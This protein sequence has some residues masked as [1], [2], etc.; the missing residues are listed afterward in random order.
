M[1][2]TAASQMIFF[3]AAMIVATAVAGVFVTTVINLS[4]DIRKEADSTSDRFNTQIQVINDPSMMQYNST[5]S[6]LVVLVKNIGTAGIDYNTVTIILNGTYFTRNN[7]TFALKDGASDWTSGVVLEI[8]LTNCTL[9]SGDH[10]MKVWAGT[11]ENVDFS[12]K[13]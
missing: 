13:I 6:T 1:P 9:G 5:C 2:G 10:K 7:M 4:K 8:T 11:R 12:F 3:I